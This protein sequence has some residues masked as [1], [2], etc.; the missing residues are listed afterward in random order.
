MGPGEMSL[1]NQSLKLLNLPSLKDDYS[2]WITYKTRIP[3]AAQSNGL[4]RHLNGTVKVPKDLIETKGQFFLP[5]N[6]AALTDD[7][8]EAYY[9]SL[10]KFNTKQAQLREIIYHTIPNS[11]FLQIKGETTA[12]AVWLKLCSIIENKTPLARDTL[13][14]KMLNLRTPEEGDVRETMDQLVTMYEELAGM[15]YKLP[16]DSYMTYICQACGGPY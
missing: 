5:G 8:I 12:S 6:S 15:G 2:N 13:Q 4:G 11:I 10:D 7:E 14:N 1:N 3:N 9:E 16:K